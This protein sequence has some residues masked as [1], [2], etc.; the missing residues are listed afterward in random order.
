MGYFEV[1]ANH[2]KTALTLKLYTYSR[3]INKGKINHKFG[4]ERFITKKS[5]PSCKGETIE[6][7]VDDLYFY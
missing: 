5:R 1:V 3:S 6:T 4:K 7:A 2:L